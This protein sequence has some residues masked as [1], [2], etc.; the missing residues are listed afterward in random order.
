MANGDIQVQDAKDELMDYFIDK[1]RPK[2][3]DLIAKI[4]KDN[5]VIF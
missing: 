2:N 3:F 1:F 4:Y 5:Q